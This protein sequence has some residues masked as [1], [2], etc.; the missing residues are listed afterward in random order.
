VSVAMRRR[1]TEIDRAL[2]SVF[3]GLDEAPFQRQVRLDLRR[4]A[5]VTYHTANSRKSDPGFP[6]L[7]GVRRRDAPRWRK[8]YAVVLEVKKESGVVDAAQIVWGQHFSAVEE[9]TGGAL[10]YR[11]VRPSTWGRIL[12]EI[13]G[14]GE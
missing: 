8:P 1:R 4:A 9:A 10:I 6:D 11:L 3:G 7:V 14:D 13:V 2:V 5:F 12:A